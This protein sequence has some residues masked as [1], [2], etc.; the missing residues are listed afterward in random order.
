MAGRGAFL[1]GW[2]GQDYLWLLRL[3]P[4]E[5]AS[6]EHEMAALCNQVVSCCSDIK[7]L[8]TKLSLR[9]D[10]AVA[11]DDF[12]ARL[13]AAVPQLSAASTERCFGVSTCVSTCA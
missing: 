8:F 2:C 3:L 5:V 12:V 6:D 10:A 1:D 9:K 11:L 7:S 4:D 13:T